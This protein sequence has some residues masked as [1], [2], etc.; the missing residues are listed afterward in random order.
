MFQIP[1]NFPHAFVDAE[2][3]VDHRSSMEVREAFHQPS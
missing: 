1:E 2:V 3:A